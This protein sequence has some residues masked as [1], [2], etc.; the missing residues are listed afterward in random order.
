MIITII[1]AEQPKGL[2]TASLPSGE[3]VVKGRSAPLRPAARKL[4]ETGKAQAED[5]L[6]MKRAGGPVD[7]RGIVG[8][9]AKQA[10][11]EDELMGP[12]V[13][14]HRPRPDRLHLTV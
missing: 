3:I 12:I 4:L 14:K 10:V 7:M 1:V 9:L 8:R 6:E 5:V 2:Y 13:V 11:R